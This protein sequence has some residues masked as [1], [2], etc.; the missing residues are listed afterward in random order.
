M[1]NE[2]HEAMCGY[3]CAHPCNT[4]H[5]EKPVCPLAPNQEEGENWK[6][7][8]YCLDEDPN[9]PPCEWLE[10]IDQAQVLNQEADG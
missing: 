9:E 2:T 4:E 1:S 5:P 6:F 3:R 10:E 8:E 7:P